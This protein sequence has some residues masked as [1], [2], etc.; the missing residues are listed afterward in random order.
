MDS[1]RPSGGG[2]SCATST[3]GRTPPAG[4][5]RYD[6]T[7]AHTSNHADPREALDALLDQP[8][9]N[10]HVE[11]TTHTHQLRVT[12]KG[13]ALLHSAAR[14][15]EV[16]APQR[17]HDQAKERLLPEDHPTLRA[18]GIS[19]AQGRVKPSRQAKYR[20]VEEFLRS[21]DAA[22]DDAIGSG[23]VRT[24]TEEDPLRVVDL[25]CGNA[26]LTLAA[27]RVAQPARMPV[28][29]VGVDVREQSRRHNTEVAE[30]LGIGDRSDVRAP[31]ASAAR[32][33]ARPTSCSRCT[34]ATPR[35]TTRW[36]GGALGGAV[37]LA[38]P[39]CHHDISRPAAPASP[40]P[41]GWTSPCP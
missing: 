15:V 14:A 29:T 8:F 7:Q 13:D 41:V 9:A 28:R 10:W 35:P 11:T 1:P 12:K 5:E 18:L 21:L 31:R 39:C 40:T 2:S 19:D 17:S 34:P 27:H 20:Q 22:L 3:S 4:H 6:E 24:A 23:K 38:A 25:G 16:E 36:P 33:E 26:Y 32:A 37:V 30:Q